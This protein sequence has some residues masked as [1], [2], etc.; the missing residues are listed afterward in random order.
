MT[1]KPSIPLV[2]LAT[3]SRQIR[4]EVLRRMGEVIDAGR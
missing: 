3:Q 2:D 4:D 1:L